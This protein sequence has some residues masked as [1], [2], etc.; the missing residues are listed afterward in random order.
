MIEDLIGILRFTVRGEAHE[1]VLCRVDL[2]S[3][4]VSERAIEEAEGVRESERLKDLDF[5]GLA[6]ANARSVP[7]PHSVH[8]QDSRVVEGRREE[9]TCRVRL[10]MGRENDALFVA[11]SERLP[12]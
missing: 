4:E 2:E 10:V 7:F 9:C 5:V 12:D 3:G 1:F 8:C 11:T 6:V